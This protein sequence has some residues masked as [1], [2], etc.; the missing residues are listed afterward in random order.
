MLWASSRMG[1]AE[2]V[3]QGKMRASDFG[4]ARRPPGVGLRSNKPWASGRDFKPM[5][6]QVVA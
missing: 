1:G 3:L 6:E 5:R 4:K 2:L